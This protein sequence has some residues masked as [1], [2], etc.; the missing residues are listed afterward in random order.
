MRFRSFNSFVAAMSVIGGVI[1]SSAQTPSPNHKHYE[2]PASYEQTVAPG[3][4][5][6]AADRQ[7]ADRAYADAMRK[8]AQAYPNDLDART[9]SAGL[10]ASVIPARRA[11]SVDPL[12]ALRYE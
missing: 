10:L 3:A 5:L 11:A 9:M 4:P 8:L 2:K 12:I 1:P 6:A 7:K